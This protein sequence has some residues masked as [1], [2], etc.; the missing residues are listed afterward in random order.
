MS[1]LVAALLLVLV[2]Q[3][4]GLCVIARARRSARRKA[5]EYSRG[6]AEAA[7]VAHDLNNLLS[8]ILNYASFVLEDLADDDPSRQ[9]VVEI[10]HAA[11]GAGALTRSLGARQGPRDVPARPRWA[12]Q[13]RRAAA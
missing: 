13:K 6:R 7:A 1:Y 9:D 11:L 12:S 8:V 2:A 3:S 4:V 10:R 5:D